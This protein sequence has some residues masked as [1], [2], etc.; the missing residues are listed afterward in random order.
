MMLLCYQPDG[1]INQATQHSEEGWDKMIERYAALG[2]TSMLYDGR[3]D[4]FEVYLKDGEVVPRPAIVFAGGDRQTVVADGVAELDLTPD[5]AC[6]I[7]I[8]HD[9]ILV[10]E[11][12]I[13]ESLQFSTDTAGTYLVVY[14][15]VFPYK[16]ARVVVEAL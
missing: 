4:I 14:E 10:H 1:R 9:G 2:I 16:P 6:P 13:G 15:E 11:H 8:Y 12:P 5:V 3:V 7:K